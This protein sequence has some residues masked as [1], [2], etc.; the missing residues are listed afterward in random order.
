MAVNGLRQCKYNVGIDIGGTKVNIGI[1]QK[2]GQLVDKVKI[3]SQQ[4]EDIEIFVDRI[5]CE[6]KRLAQKCGIMIEE[7]EF[8]GLGVPGTV[9]MRSGIVEYCP[10]L[11]W[12]MVPLKEY[13]QTIFLKQ[14][15]QVIQDSWAG[16][17]AEHEFGAGI[18]YADMTCITLGTG[19]GGGIIA[20]N[21]IFSGGMHCAGEIGHTIIE[22]DGR[23]C[24]CGNC[25]CLEKYASGNGIYEQ[26]LECFPEKL[27][28][29]KEGAESVFEL[30]YQGYEPALRL[31]ENS[32][33]MLAVGLANLVG[34]ISTEAII[35]SGGLCEHEELILKPLQ[36][37]ILEYGYH[38]W[39]RQ[40]RLV[41][42]QAKLGSDAPMIGAAF[43]YKGLGI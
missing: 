43:I 25:G 2:T 26:A 27:R 29:M 22:K 33:Q 23:G 19:I 42:R 1:F 5:G 6:L 11:F 3:P 37:Y 21:R 20:N 24:N 39:T 9:D 34:I 14:E 12:D 31:I 7:I 4:G 38:S 18:G 16:A 15:I 10:N 40:N 30:A 28:G 36:K 8:I 32:V 41:V 17:L 35:I 13:F